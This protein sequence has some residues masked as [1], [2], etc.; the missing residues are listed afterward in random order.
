MGETTPWQFTLV[1]RHEGKHNLIFVLLVPVLYPVV[2]FVGGNSVLPPGAYSYMFSRPELVITP[3]MLM[4]RITYRRGEAT[5]LSGTKNEYQKTSFQD[6]PETTRSTSI[7]LRHR[8]RR[9]ASLLE[10]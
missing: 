7:P 5:K 6:A 10:T 3:V 9:V 8:H 1:D 2:N 4:S